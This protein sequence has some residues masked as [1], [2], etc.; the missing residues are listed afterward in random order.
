MG[1]SVETERYMYL[2][3]TFTFFI[4][5][6]L[7]LL[8]SFFDV[9]QS[10]QH[11]YVVYLNELLC[12]HL[13]ISSCENAIKKSEKKKHNCVVLLAFNS[14]VSSLLL[15]ISLSLSLCYTHTS[16]KTHVWPFFPLPLHAAVTGVLCGCQSFLTTTIS[17]WHTMAH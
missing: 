8:L 15:S 16:T 4:V 12:I 3:I 11:V 2:F 7:L 14:L 9:I 1:R 10:L 13:W 5:F 6:C 17:K